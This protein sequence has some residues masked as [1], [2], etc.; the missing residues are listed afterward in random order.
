MFAA[1]SGGQELWEGWSGDRG[2][3]LNLPVVLLLEAGS[4][5]RSHGTESFPRPVV[6]SVGTQKLPGFSPKWMFISVKLRNLGRLCPWDVHL[7]VEMQPVQ[8][9][10]LRLSI[11]TL[12]SSAASGFWCDLPPLGVCSPP[13]VLRELKVFLWS[14][15]FVATRDIHLCAMQ[16]YFHLL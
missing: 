8:A 1:V 15:C 2:A 6:H 14:C 13:A 4:R 5:M 16:I 11:H 12:V 9:P 10:P 3:S 7:W